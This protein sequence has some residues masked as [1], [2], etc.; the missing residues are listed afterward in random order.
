M[1]TDCSAAITGVFG[2]VGFAER[3]NGL[4]AQT[5][6]R[7]HPHPAAMNGALALLPP[8]AAD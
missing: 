7:P 3:H 8:V 1:G 4:R 6:Q 5:P 2:L